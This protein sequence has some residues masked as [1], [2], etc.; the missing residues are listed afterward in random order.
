MGS[1]HAYFLSQIDMM[2][3]K[4]KPKVRVRDWFAHS[5]MCGCLESEVA[6]S[7]NN[8]NNNNKKAAKKIRSK[9]LETWLWKKAER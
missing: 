7:N 1:S 8:K 4:A 6:N 3:E 9:G 5:C 2:E